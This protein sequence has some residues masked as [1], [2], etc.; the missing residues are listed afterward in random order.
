MTYLIAGNGPA[1]VSAVRA[2]REEDASGRIVMVSPEANEPY[3]RITV[4][5]LMVGEIDEPDIY[6]APGFYAITSTQSRWRPVR[7]PCHRPEARCAYRRSG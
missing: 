5:E 6:F 4:P 7:Q 3:S 2:I 1:A